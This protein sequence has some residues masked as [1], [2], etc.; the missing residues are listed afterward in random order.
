MYSAQCESKLLTGFVLNCME[1]LCSMRRSPYDFHQI[2][3][4]WD[5][6]PGNVMHVD[7]WNSMT[8]SPDAEF[9]QNITKLNYQHSNA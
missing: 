2:I 8:I 3:K 6:V 1:T 9:V 7:G 4:H 5:Y